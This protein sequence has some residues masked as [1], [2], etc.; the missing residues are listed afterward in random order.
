MRARLIEIVLPLLIDENLDQRILRGVKLQIPDFDYW[1][2]QETTLKGCEDPSLLSRAATQGLIL[3][4]HD[5]NTV[6]RHAYDRIRAGE[7]MAA[8]VISLTIWQ[9]EQQ[10]QNL[11][12]SSSAAGHWSSWIR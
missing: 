2:V 12:P 6:P 11:S 1:V 4:T 7:R 3:M 10:S 9:S 5:V 8:V